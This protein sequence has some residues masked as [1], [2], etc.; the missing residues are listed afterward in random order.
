MEILL[1]SAIFALGLFGLRDLRG[2]C[3]LAVVLV[4]ASKVLL[5]AADGAQALQDGL[6]DAA[7]L[8]RQRVAASWKEYELQ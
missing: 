4:M 7:R 3:S 6:F 2:R 8:A 5:V 1:L